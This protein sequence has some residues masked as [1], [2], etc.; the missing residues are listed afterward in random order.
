MYKECGQVNDAVIQEIW[1]GITVYGSE[2]SFEEYKELV[3]EM[4]GSMRTW[5][6]DG[7]NPHDIND[8][9]P[10]SDSYSE[11]IGEGGPVSS[12][13]LVE[14]NVGEWLQYTEECS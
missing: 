2:Y 5:A 12:I 11:E 14:V 7:I 4:V 1:S 3:D 13:K 10:L 8:K 9:L 6:R